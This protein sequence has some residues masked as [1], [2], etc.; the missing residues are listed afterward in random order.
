MTY[1]DVHAHIERFK[2]VDAV[3][4]NARKVGV[5]II[6]N[7][8]N[9]VFANM[10]NL[11]LIKLYPEV[12]AAMGLYP[13]EA[14]DRGDALVHKTI[15]FIGNNKDNIIAVGEVGIDLKYPKQ[16]EKQKI[17]FQKFI[18]L[19]IELDKAIIVHS[20]KAELLCVDMLEEAGMKRVLLHCFSGRH[21]LLKRI[22]NNEWF[23]GVP[24][25]V[26]YNEQIKKLVEL[27]P[28][29]N[30]LCETDS[31]MLHPDR[32]KTIKNEPSNVLESYKAIAKIKKLSLKIVE[33][34]I[35]KNYERLFGLK[36]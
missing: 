33:K 10:R 7:N 36:V 14:V 3:I 19:A 26:N 34:A 20:R 16:V 12:K 25:S 28:L 29:D 27:V 22:V 11:E 4:E 31:P 32:D 6:V 21:S 17:N 5:G 15:E 30:L 2:K 1:I 13:L 8:G 35:E 18:D 23:I 24:S 9:D